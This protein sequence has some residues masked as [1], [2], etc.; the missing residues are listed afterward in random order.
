MRSRG[1]SLETNSLHRSTSLLTD[2]FQCS[3]IDLSLLG[4]EWNGTNAYS[5]AGG[6]YARQR[7]RFVGGKRFPLC[8]SRCE[9]DIQASSLTFPGE[10]G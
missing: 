9:S 8:E 4:G 2:F 10:M 6:S 1:R 7:W 3:E 5:S